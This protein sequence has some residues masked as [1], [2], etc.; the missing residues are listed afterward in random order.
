MILFTKTFEVA[1]E[2]QQQVGEAV[3]QLL[4]DNPGGKLMEIK[5]KLI[6]TKEM[7]Y[8]KVTV[9]FEFVSEKAYK[10]G[11]LFNI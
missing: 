2:T 11:E 3:E 7:D 6:E 8:I 5:Q 10:K 4:L 9:K 1:V